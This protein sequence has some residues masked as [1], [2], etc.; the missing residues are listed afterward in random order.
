MNHAANNITDPC[1]RYLDH[2][3]LN[4]IIQAVKCAKSIYNKDELRTAIDQLFSD[5]PEIRKIDDST[6]FFRLVREGIAVQALAG[7]GL[8]LDEA[9][10]RR[11]ILIRRGMKLPKPVPSYDGRL[12][13]R[14][15]IGWHLSD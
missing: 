8:S 2:E 1:T 13:Q 10:R 15:Q 5:L 4:R 7:Q 12:R 9:K 3:F 6:E 14:L 11:V